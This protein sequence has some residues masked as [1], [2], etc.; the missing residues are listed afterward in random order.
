MGHSIQCSWS[1]GMSFQAAA[2]GH[3]LTMD[4]GE[5]TGGEGSGFRPKPLLLVSLAGCTG[6]DVMSLLAKMRVQVDGFD[7]D[8]HGELTDEHPKYYHKIHLTYRFRGEQIDRSKV[9]KAVTLS[10]E[11]YC[12]VSAML[13]KAAE[14]SFE[15]IYE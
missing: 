15:I 2:T 6:M 14:L 12:G 3:K 8:V 11:K 7:I 10:Q 1:G 5:G 9:E 4:A 13:R